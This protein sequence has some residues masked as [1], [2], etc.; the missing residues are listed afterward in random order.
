MEI[1]DKSAVR[2]TRTSPK[3]YNTVHDLLHNTTLRGECMEWNGAKDRYGYPAGGV[4]GIIKGYLLHREVFRMLN[5][6][7]PEVVMHTCDNRACVN[8]EH[9]QAGTHVENVADKVAKRRQAR[10]EH[11]GN[12]KLSSSEVAEMRA[13]HKAGYSYKTLQSKFNVARA[14]VW[15]VTSGKN[16]G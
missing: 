9:L 14:T 15:R 10:G 6:Y 12:A 5:G 16:W 13:L 1:A 2:R 7:L 8:P 4:G 11:N 3:K